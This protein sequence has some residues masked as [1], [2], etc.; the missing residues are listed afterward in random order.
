MTPAE[1]EAMGPE[2]EQAVRE[3]R[4]EPIDPAVVEAAA[5]RVW[6]KLG[7]AAQTRP[8]EHIRGCADFQA[9]I[10]ELR[11]GRLPAAR[12]TLLRDHL[13][14]CV[15]CR[16]V[17]EGR[18]VTMPAARAPKAASYTFRWAA[19]AAILAAGGL[20][21]WIA[22]DRFGGHTGR[23][24]VQTVNGTL[25]EV[26][27][28][29]VRPMA[30]GQDLPDGVEIRT[31][32]DSGAMLELR[33]GS[34]V[35]LRERS[36]FSTTQDA[37][38][39]TVH[40]N[41][42][43]V[44]VQAA[45]RRKGHLYVATADCRVAV[46][47]TLFSVSSGVKGS[48]VSVIE[49]EVHVS[50]DN[51][52]KILHPGDQTVTSASLEPL[53][54]REDVA[55]SRNREKLYQQLDALRQSLQ[56][57]HLPAL[58]YESRLLGK[59]PASTAVYASIPNLKE[60]LGEAQSVFRE[61]LQN[62]PEL[63]DWWAG[64]GNEIEPVIERLRA[65]SEYLGDE[66]VLAAMAGPDGRMVGPV[67]F[68]ETRRDGFPEF[69]KKQ[70]L[71][72]AIETR[73]GL[74]WFGMKPAVDALAAALD[75][76]DTGFR[77]TPFY[78]RVSEVY[79]NGAGLMLCADLA[80]LGQNRNTGGVRYFVAEQ[81][82][83]QGQM[84][85]RATAGFEGPRTGMA[86]W[87]ADPAPMG[88]L[89]YVSPDATLVTAFVVKNPAAIID[90]LV[91]VQQRSPAA[92]RD[93]LA[94]AQ[95]ATGVD[96]R[97]DLAAALGGEFS[98]SVDGPIMPVP[99]WKLVV[100]AYE[101]AKVQAT[102]QKLID[103]LN[104]RAAAKGEKPLRTGQESFEGRTYYMVAAADPNPLTEAHYTFVDGYLIAGPT[105][106][107]V[108]RALQVKSSGTSIT[109]ATQ[110]RTM[111]PRDHHANYSAVVYQNL[112]STLA[113][114]A[115]LLGA[116]VPQGKSAPEFA[117]LTNMKPTLLAAYAEPQTVTIAGSGEVF[118]AGI[119]NVLHG[120]L[121]GVVGNA[122]PIGNFS[123]TRVH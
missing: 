31:A 104:Q 122:F 9:L 78:E 69:L 90:E 89:E 35:E 67:F 61:K 53:S 96:I 37:N 13:H 84:Q 41:R 44:I 21:V 46:T 72:F 8:A 80:R 2:L 38:D 102:L 62:S 30:A 112:G 26:S 25:Y 36:G 1:F 57:I 24:F 105:R 22:V 17:Y 98:L 120:S 5:A 27:S 45:K 119:T 82:E 65:G 10:P 75:Q 71:P 77:S 11:A 101:P 97:N 48:R 20:S 47:G 121:L 55:W 56:Q 3:I 60:Y 83:V 64:K 123:G 15:A 7:E 4:E 51:D 93:A 94:S 50:Q 103:A 81:K 39:I 86:A 109:H 28:A 23:A 12:S 117:K 63:R 107:L 113:P 66:V 106:A 95:Q 73:P 85:M 99:S 29:G 68:A 115:G 76:P 91:G 6:A 114:I 88:S 33:D 74:V 87:L 100:E 49:G 118:G 40:L 116:F 54:I 59:L 79:R 14:E 110:F 32:K 70:G 108:S 43:S 19:A 42:G 34:V 92:A 18:V 52:E 58:R 111:E 16:K